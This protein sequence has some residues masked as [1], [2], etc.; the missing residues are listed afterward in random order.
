MDKGGEGK[1]KRKGKRKMG[2]RK[3]NLTSGPHSG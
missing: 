1:N 2:K 3:K